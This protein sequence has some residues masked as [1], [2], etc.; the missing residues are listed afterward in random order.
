MQYVLIIL[1]A[2]FLFPLAAYSEVQNLGE[3]ED[4][5]RESLLFDESDNVVDVLS[6][7]V[8]IE[9][10]CKPT[11]A[12]RDRHSIGED[13]DSIFERD[14]FDVHPKQGF[15]CSIC[16]YWFNV[17]DFPVCGCKEKPALKDS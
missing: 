16:T 6:D 17:F 7:G 3:K 15:S 1:S 14:I 4:C 5:T 12:C 10:G 8:E 11:K 9:Y 2:I 13:D